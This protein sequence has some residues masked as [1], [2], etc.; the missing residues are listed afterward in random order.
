MIGKLLKVRLA[1]L[2]QSVFARGSKSAKKRGIG[3]KIG[4]G[5]LAV[6]VVAALSGTMG[7][8]FDMVADP[9]IQIGLGSVALS[10]LCL[11]AVGMCVI[12]SIFI[13]A[14]QLFDAKDNE[15][16]L[17]MPIKASDILLSRVL[18]VLVVNA[19]Y[20][21]LVLIP[22]MVVYAMRASVGVPHIVC[23]VL[24]WLFVSLLST[25]LSCLVGF[26]VSLISSHTKNNALISMVIMVAF[27]GAYFA[28]IFKLQDYLGYLVAN[29]ASIGASLKKAFPPAYFFGTSIADGNFLSLLWLG[30][31]SVIPFVLV[32]VVLSKSFIFVI[33]TKR[34]GGKK[35]YKAKKVAQ[36]P[37]MATLIGKEFSRLFSQPT[38]MLNS[39]LGAFMALLM[40]GATIVKKDVLLQL[41]G[42]PGLEQYL[43][44]AVCAMLCFCA[45]TTCT[46]A[47]SLS[48]EGSSFWV[49]RSAPI[50]TKTIL[51]AKVYTNLCLG[52]PPLVISGLII[53]IVTGSN[54]FVLMV[55]PTVFMVFV[56]LLGMCGNVLYPRFDWINATT[57]I[58]NSPGVL[59]GTL[60]P[61]GLM[62]GLGF[63][64]GVV[65]VNLISLTAFV[66]LV[67]GLLLVV[68]ALM[69]RWLIDTGA[70][71]CENM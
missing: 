60:L 14:N 55:V 7:V 40:A 59:I 47:P 9:L 70:K 48:L 13:T 6:Y 67:S 27:L 15:L 26:V 64:Y 3:F 25:A 71:K 34:G 22:G 39:S 38:Y 65:L 58:K 66:L 30:L 68:S 32:M 44:G 49:L 11:M 50:E 31:W 18:L 54:V 46:T 62:M 17:S 35:V 33:T 20:S 37:L 28:V 57:V 41:T 16:L 23:F 1:Y 21:A 10:M 56:S 12:G 8:M 61:M 24:A 63:L 5:F 4:A 43:A 45:T 51:L 53:G 52:V 19:V 2:Y 42:V 36:K 69:Y 29:G